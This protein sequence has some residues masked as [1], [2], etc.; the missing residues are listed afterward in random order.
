MPAYINPTEFWRLGLPIDTLFQDVGMQPGPWTTPIKLGTGSGTMQ[1]GPRSNPHDQYL[2]T[3][4][5]MT[6]GEIDIFGL[7]NPGLVPSFALS[8]DGVLFSPQ[9][10]FRPNQAGVIP[11]IYEGFTLQFENGVTP[12]SFVAGDEWAFGTTPSPDVVEF[13]GVAS[14][15]VDGFLRN[16]YHLPL[17]SWGKDLKLA[18]AAFARWF[19]LQKRGLSEKQD[20]KK[21]DPVKWETW[22]EGVRK[23]EI[24]PNFLDTAP[25]TD[26]SGY[27]QPRPPY[28]NDLTWRH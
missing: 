14:D 18:V 19:F 2:V 7:E 16:H 8:Y 22:L 20:F 24:Q 1:L 27:V 17:L 21:H 26:W 10:Y 3:V 13:I 15:Y 4:R 9:P 6:G 11:V 5:C 28:L 23:G 12:P 25:R